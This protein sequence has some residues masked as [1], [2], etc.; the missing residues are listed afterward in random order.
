M[1]KKFIEHFDTSGMNDA[2]IKGIAAIGEVVDKMLET[3][4]GEEFDAKAFKSSLVE[5]MKGM[6]EFKKQSIEGLVKSADFEAKVKEISEEILILKKFT[7]KGADGQERLK[8]V[9]EQVEMQFKDYIKT[10]NGRVVVDL[11]KACEESGN[12]KKTITLALE[13]KAVS[14]VLSGGVAPHMSLAVDPVLDVEPR[15]ETFVRKFA[16]VSSINARSLIIAEFVPGEGDAE[17]VPEGNLKPAMDA[18]LQERTVNAGK[19]AL[20]AKVSEETIYDLPQLI[21]EIQTEL[22]Y[23]VGLAEESG[24]LNG[25]GAN[26][27]I[28]GVL[29]TVPAYVITGLSVA[30]ANHFDAI[31]AAYTQ[32]VSTSNSAYRPNL[33]IMHPI[34]YAKM[35]LTKD[36]NGQYLRPFSFNGEL[37][38]GLRVETSTA[39]EQGELIVGDFNYLNIRDYQLFQITFGWENDDFTKN[40]VTMIGEKRLMAYIKRQY[41]TAFVYDTFNNI[42]TAL[43]A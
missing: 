1:K 20:T 12:R 42:E 11:K 30:N 6:D 37:V 28:V 16:N 33:V 14:T 26:G 29:P 39:I 31:V 7:E 19:V 40:L 34:D 36:A 18:T 17:W 41:Q 2:E 24:I 35:Q 32:I 5:E 9:R 21:A 38:P 10:E 25:T 3:N 27:E 15:S 4:K 23:R 13:K 43:T 22:V 8:S